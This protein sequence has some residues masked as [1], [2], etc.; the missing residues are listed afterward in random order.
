MWIEI[1]VEDVKSRF[2]IVELDALQNKQVAE[3]QAD[4]IVE[5]IAE[6]VSLVRGFVG[7]NPANTL[8]EGDTIPIKLKSIVLNIIRYEA[9]NRLGQPVTEDRKE[10]YKKAFEVLKWVK[11]GT[12]AISDPV[13]ASTEEN[14]GGITVVTKRDRQVTRQQMNGLF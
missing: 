3:G 13:T 12:F 5:L 1:T 7:G 8:G 6:T 2:A 9:L 10:S 14:S 4:P 11:D